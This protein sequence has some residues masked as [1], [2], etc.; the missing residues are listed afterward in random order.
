MITEESVREVIDT[1]RVE[2][3]VGDFVNLRRRGNNFT[4]LCPFHNEKTPSFNVNPARN[5]YKCFGCG[6]GGDP[7]KF[8]MEL[9]QL[10]FPDAIRWI[11]QKYNIKLEETE[12]SEEVRAELQEKDSLIITN[13]F[14]RQYYEDQLHQT[15]EGKSV[16]LSYFRSRGFRKET[17]QTFGLGYAPAASDGLLQAARAAGY[18][19]EQLE[20]L[21]LVRNG[22]DFFRDRVM[23]TIHNLGGKPI[24][25][26]GRI[27]RKDAR[28][29]KYIN[30]PETEIYHKSD[31]LY[32]M[33]Q[34]RQAI[35][36]L[37]NIYLVEGYTDVISLHQNGIRNVA[38]T[39]GTSLTTGQANLVK[40]FTENVTLLY[41]GDK[42]GVKAALRGVDVLL[43]ADLNVKVVV[44]PD[45]EDPDGYMQKVGA[46]AFEKYLE[47]TRKDFL[48]FKADIL[49]EEAGSDVAARTTA[50]RDIGA[51]LA[52]VTDPLKRAGYLQQFSGK[53]G[54]DESL[55]V[56][57]V[58]KAIADRRTESRKTQER[59]ERRR[60][61]ER[62]SPDRA[63]PTAPPTDDPDEWGGMDEPAWLAGAEDEDL[64]PE[65]PVGM[66]T[67]PAAPTTPAE[68]P[69]EIGHGFQEKYFVQL[70][71]RDGHK[72]YDEAS[73][74][75]V[76]QF[77]TANVA[78]VLGD[79]DVERY[80]KIVELVMHY[81]QSNGAPPPVD[82]YSR[83]TEEGVRK[84]A[85]EALNSPYTYSPNWKDKYGLRL[86]QKMPEENHRLTAEIFLRIFRME[87]IERKGR[88][89]SRLVAQYEREGNY[90]KL[91]T[92]LKVQMKLDEMRLAL[93]KELGTVVLSR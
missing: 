5:I 86:S 62:R 90:D 4:G 41:D 6:V 3:V 42:A 80:R 18:K 50:I 67:A 31:V 25:F 84:L 87:K 37:D 38:A 1:A 10:S 55:L 56:Q 39:S 49:L 35:R 8:L 78:D 7:V 20:K 16:G 82:W 11:A 34:A 70:L 22:R 26:A 88:E 19:E 69:L 21:G 61:R 73:N 47:E 30:S 54:L 89:N 74:T 32:G 63:T 23:F 72:P 45:G 81:L 44:L 93:A 76:A 83:H 92:H 12:V 68:V 57:L 77:L 51:T 28:A 24:A 59:E 17:L 9:E 65:G 60:Q 46:T 36:K 2:D 13:D 43:M 91:R 48:F 53:L 33:Y 71:I 15:D 85:V 14:A 79:F 29:P 27:L 40:R 75:S 58:N 52:L 64:P 66:P